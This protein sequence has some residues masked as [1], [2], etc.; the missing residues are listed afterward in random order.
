VISN[1]SFRYVAP[2]SIEAASRYLS[3]EKNVFFLAGGTD[4]LPQIKCGLKQPSLL[5]DLG[6]IEPLKG[7]ATRGEGL[8]IGAMETLGDL[9][10][11]A[12]V[13]KSLPLLAHS[14]LRVASPQIRNRATLVGNILQE[15]RCLYFNQSDYWRQSMAPCLKLR[16]KVCHQIPDSQT[17]RALYYSDM[18]PVLLALDA[19]VEQYDRGTFRL[20]ALQDTIRPHIHGEI[21]KRLLTGIFVPYPDPGTWARFVKQGVRAAVDFSSLN[22]AVRVTSP[23]NGKGAVVRIFVGASSPEPIELKETADFMIANLP[24]LLDL[25]EEV[26][27]RAVKELSAKSVLVRETAISLKAK[28]SSFYLIANVLEDLF[29]ALYSG[30]FGK[31]RS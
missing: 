26:K 19:Q 25:K 7:A 13:N 18:A 24:G 10:R 21:E 28:K 16:G 20:T 27:E 9:V 15:R 1:N 6:K 3:T 17:C 22:V 5:V 30:A 11:N 8:F 29:S 12:R 31:E 23:V 2:D 4:L 14:A